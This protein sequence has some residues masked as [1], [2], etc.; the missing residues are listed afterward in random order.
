MFVDDRG[1]DT[2]VKRLRRVFEIDPS[3]LA[4]N[5]DCQ[6]TGYKFAPE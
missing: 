5:P 3:Q 6:G 2:P 4:T 1:G